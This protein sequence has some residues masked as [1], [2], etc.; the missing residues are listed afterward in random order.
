MNNKKEIN[1]ILFYL[2]FFLDKIRAKKIHVK[3]KNE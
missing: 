3:N 2:N 1:F